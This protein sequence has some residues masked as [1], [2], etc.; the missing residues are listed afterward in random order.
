MF[1]IADRTVHMQCSLTTFA[2]CSNGVCKK[3]SARLKKPKT[4][5]FPSATDETARPTLLKTSRLV[6]DF[7]CLLLH[8]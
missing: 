3:S 5:T 2:P 8:G 6:R 1:A 4:D 7:F